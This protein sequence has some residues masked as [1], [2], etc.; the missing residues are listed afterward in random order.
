MFSERTSVGLD[1]HARSVVACAIDTVSRELIRSRLTPR[2]PEVLDWLGPLPGPVVVAYE[3]GP[4]GFGL[5]RS[6]SAARVRCEVVAPSRLKRPAAERIK[7][8]AR[9]ALHL[10]KLLRL[11]AFAAVRYLRRPRKRHGIWCVPGSG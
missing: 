5:A 8:N 9:D 6:L 4:T 10:A 2:Y 3:A 11:D 7:T 1:V